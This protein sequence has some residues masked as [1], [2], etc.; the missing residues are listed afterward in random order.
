MTNTVLRIS[1]A[2]VCLL[3]TSLPVSAQQ[4]RVRLAHA[5]APNSVLAACAEQFGNRMKT[6]QFEVQIFGSGTLGQP[7]QLLTSVAA[8]QIDMA[9]VPLTSAV[10]P[11]FGIFELPFLIQDRG[12]VRRISRE[13]VGK[14]LAPAAQAKGV[15]LLAMWEDGFRDI[16]TNSRPIK[17]PADLK[18]L[19]LRVLPTPWMRTAF[20][21][22]GANPVPVSFA[23]VPTALQTGSIDGQESTLATIEAWKLQEI[24]RYLSL[25]RHVYT[26]AFLIVSPSFFARL[27]QPQQA[28]LIEKAEEIQDFCMEL[29]AD[30][31]VG[32]VEKLRAVIGVT[33][34]DMRPFRSASEGIYANFANSTQS[35]RQLIELARFSTHGTGGGGDPCPLDQ[36]R[37]SNNTCAKSCCK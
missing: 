35:G 26:P 27:S 19:K 32:V 12:H 10:A 14:F 4:L 37:C 2:L 15:R 5:A 29:G 6:N 8:A 3:I 17:A 22:Y 33:L 13:L 21:N 25:T 18:G 23:D 34:V 30:R 11:E 24:Q 9:L 20:S 1:I 28:A 31:E 16:T 36:C 7:N